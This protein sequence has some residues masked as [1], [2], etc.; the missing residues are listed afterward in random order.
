MLLKSLPTVIVLVF[1]STILFAQQKLPFQGKLIQDNQ[2]VNGN[3]DLL[4]TIEEA[5]WSEEYNQLFI[6]DGYYSVVLG[7]VNPLPIDLFKGNTDITLVISV[8]G[9]ALSPVKLYSPLIGNLNGNQQNFEILNSDK[10]LRLLA[11]IFKPN[12][13]GA[14]VLFGSNDSLNVIVGSSNPTRGLISVNDSLGRSAVQLIAKGDDNG[15]ITISS[16]GE[17]KVILDVF[18]ENNAGGMLLTGN[19]GPVMWLPDL[20]LKV[21]AVLCKY[22][23]RWIMWR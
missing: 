19:N 18:S 4:F 3:H 8:D 11:D 16:N 2:V 17:R 6:L 12:D 10:K 13:S 5:N 21:P 23:I 15:E 14:L 20:L 22:M 9:V 7:S 1:I